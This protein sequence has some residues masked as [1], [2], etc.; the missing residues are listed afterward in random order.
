MYA[1]FK[2]TQAKSAVDGQLRSRVDGQPIENATGNNGEFD[3]ENPNIRYSVRPSK[4]FTDLSANQKSFLDKIGPEKLPQVLADRW[5]QLTDN[6]GLRIR[7]AGVDRY[8]S[9]LRNDKALYGAD[10]LE[11]SIA[12]SSWVLA[13][14]SPAAG[15]AVHA[16]LN[17]G[18]IYLTATRR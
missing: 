16:L 11:G 12:D 9:L 3:P 6:L 18:R 13:R 5:R 1:W 8:A 14:M 15:G 10:T 2:P 7:Q 17:N 4:I